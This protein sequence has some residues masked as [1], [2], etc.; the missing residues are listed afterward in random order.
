LTV[1]VLHMVHHEPHQER[2]QGCQ[3]TGDEQVEVANS[4]APQSALLTRHQAH[5]R[6]RQGWGGELAASDDY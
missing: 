3:D 5:E 1:L 4:A 6:G 2:R